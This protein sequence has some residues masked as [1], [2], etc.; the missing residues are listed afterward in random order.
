VCKYSHG[1]IENKFTFSHLYNKILSSNESGRFTYSVL[2]F[3]IVNCYT[4]KMHTNMSLTYNLPLIVH[5]VSSQYC[6][7]IIIYYYYYHYYYLI[8]I[9]FPH[10]FTEYIP[11]FFS[12]E[13]S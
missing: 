6:N 12:E 1:Y 11:V 4:D 13:T 3:F 8:I 7:G 5:V 2:T 10:V 9:H